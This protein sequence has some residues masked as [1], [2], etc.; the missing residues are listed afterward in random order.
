[1]K[2]L[3][4]ILPLLCLAGCAD[5]AGG[6]APVKTPTAVLTQKQLEDPNLTPEARAQIQAAQQ[7]ASAMSQGMQKS[8]PGGG[9]N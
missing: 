2:T 3:F 5:D 8:P 7:S 1:M 9:G 4:L 6:N